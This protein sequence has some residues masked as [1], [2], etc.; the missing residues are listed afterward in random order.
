MQVTDNYNNGTY[1]VMR[2]QPIHPEHPAGHRRGL[3]LSPAA[4][5]AARLFGPVRFV[6]RPLDQ[7]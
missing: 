3:R 5:P 1:S 4:L 2:N 7:A 6:P